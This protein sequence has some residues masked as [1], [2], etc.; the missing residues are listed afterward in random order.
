MNAEKIG[1]ASVKL[2]AGRITKDDVI[3]FTAGIKLIKKTGDAV[4]CG[5]VIAIL[6]TNNEKSIEA[7]EDEFLSGVKFGDEAQKAE[8]L[9]YKP[10]S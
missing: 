5:D 7:A 3:D 1:L 9:V 6:Y 4:K 10:V 2:G 8:P